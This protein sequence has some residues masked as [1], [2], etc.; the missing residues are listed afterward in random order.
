MSGSLRAAQDSFDDPPVRTE[1]TFA[2]CPVIPGPMEV[3]DM[4]Q[5][6]EKDFLLRQ[7]P[8]VRVVLII[9]HKGND[10]STIRDVVSRKRRSMAPHRLDV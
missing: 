7:S 2:V 4:N 6:D 5:C 9:L 3:C 10:S 1:L 8:A